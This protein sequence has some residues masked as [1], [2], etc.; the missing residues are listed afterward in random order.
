MKSIIATGDIQY[1]KEANIKYMNEVNSLKAKY[2]E[3]AKNKTRERAAQLAGTSRVNAKIQ[4]NPDISKKEIK[5]LKDQSL[6]KARLEVGAKRKKIEI[7]DREWEAIQSGAVNKTLLN[8][9]LKFVDMDII[10]EKAMPKST[11]TLSSAQLRRVNAMLSSGK[12][13]YQQ[14]ADA[15]GVSISTIRNVMKGDN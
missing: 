11:T 4:S 2:N 15:I 10:R 14:V 5:K 13:T 8:N 1:S 9:L 7:T 12:Y 3:S 6:Q